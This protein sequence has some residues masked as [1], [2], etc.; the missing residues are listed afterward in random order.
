MGAGGG[1]HIHV[2]VI[3][4]LV[5]IHD[6]VQ[7]HGVVQTG[8]DVTGAPGS[9]T[10]EVR[11]ADGQG[12]HAALE[13]GADGS[14]KNPE[15]VLVG[16]LDANDGI[17]AEHEG[18]DIQGR[19]GAEG[20]HPCGVG[21]DGLNDSVY[22]LILGIDG[23]FQPLAG[24]RHPSGVQVGAEAD[25]AAVLGGVGLHALEA[26]LGV[27]QYAGT[28]A[29]GDGGVVGQNA[30]IPRAAAIVGDEPLIGLDVAEAQAAPVDIFL[31]HGKHLS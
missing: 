8:L 21:T 25:D 10:V 17:V 23:H 14:G 9:R 28:L 11:D 19:T 29:H 4:L 12:L 6:V 18:A 31:F 22:E 15:L 3:A 20:G 7:A 30:V 24:L 1:V 26:G 16:G 13:V 5:G 27:L 2:L